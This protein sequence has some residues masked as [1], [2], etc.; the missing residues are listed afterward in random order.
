MTLNDPLANSLSHI[1][2]CEKEGKKECIVRNASGVIKRV[3]KL[4]QELNYIGEF[5]EI[6]SSRETVLKVSLIGA[7]NQCG[8][9]KPRFPVKKEDFE[10][11][12]K[13]YLPAKNFGV[14]IVSTSH[15]LMTHTQAIDQQRGG[16]LIAYCY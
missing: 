14:L 7:I 13:R 15:G 3:L 12:E 5:E 16:R 8:A 4:L 1:F 6:K 9:I 10:K 2:N 11:Y